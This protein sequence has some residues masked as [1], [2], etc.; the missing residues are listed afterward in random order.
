MSSVSDLFVYLLCGSE[1]WCDRRPHSTCIDTH[2]HNK[3][4]STITMCF[5]DVFINSILFSQSHLQ[6]S[7]SICTYF[8]CVCDRDVRELCIFSSSLSERGH[9]QNIYEIIVLAINAKNIKAC[10]FTVHI[11]RNECV[12][13]KSNR[14]FVSGFELIA[15]SEGRRQQNGKMQPKRKNCVRHA[16]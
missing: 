5:I 16:S 11:Y 6:F 15:V 1:S 13:R 4:Q 8:Y 14:I 12:S 2:R 9:G 3:I 7:I 10:E